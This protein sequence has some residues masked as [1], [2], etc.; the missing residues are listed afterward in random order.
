VD[1]E[2][3]EDGF[4]VVYRHDEDVGVMR[5]ADRATETLDDRE[6]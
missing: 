3:R 2:R 4:I 6:G 5:A 1:R